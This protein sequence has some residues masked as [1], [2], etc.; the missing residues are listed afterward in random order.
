MFRVF[1]SS[2]GE[3]AFSKAPREVQKEV[4]KELELLSQDD[5]RYRRVRKLGGSNNRYRLR[6]GR[7][8][9]LFILKNAEIE[10]FDIFSKKGR[11]DYRR[12]IK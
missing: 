7:W 12:R 8:R 3:R 1:F 11:S 5:F 4:V 10:I 9:I 2:S 6:I